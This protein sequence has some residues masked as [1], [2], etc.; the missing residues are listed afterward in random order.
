MTTN[1]FE[2]EA[3]TPF[4]NIIVPRMTHAHHELS[5]ALPY[6]DLIPLNLADDSS[7]GDGYRIRCRRGL[8]HSNADA[9][10]DT[11]V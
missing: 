2:L 6:F 1:W 3:T 5:R 11:V 4:Q 8:S 9:D 7:N 10:A